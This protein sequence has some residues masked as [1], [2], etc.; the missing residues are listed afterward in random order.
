VEKQDLSAAQE[1]IER[2]LAFIPARAIYVAAKV[3]VADLIKDKSLPAAQLAQELNIDQD[4]L[5]RILR[6]LVTVGMFTQNDEG[7]FSLTS[8]GQTLRSDTPDSVRDYII[9]Y[10]E[11]GYQTFGNIMHTVWTGKAADVETF[12]TPIFQYLKSDESVGAVFHA[13]LRSRGRIE[14]ASL[15][16]AY[17]FSEAGKVVDV[18]GGTGALLSAI[19]ARYEN[20][21]AILFDSEPVIQQAQAERGGPLPRCELVAG[22][23]FESVPHGGDTYILKF[24]LHDWYDEDAMRIL[25]RCR[26]AMNDNARLLIIEGLIERT[27]KLTITDVMDLTMLVSVGGMERTENEYTA[28]LEKSD[29][30]LQRIV[31]TSAA[32]FVLE[33]APC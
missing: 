9:L 23:F 3:G 10:H 29:F 14:I 8:L 22:D 17:D 12:G 28:L 11:L 6:V 21:E 19:L 15:L 5:S 31:P 16:E 1:T 30:R 24:V 20:L 4:A 27:D 7:R 18:G 2:S 26:Q 13:G 32:P 33:A 25:K